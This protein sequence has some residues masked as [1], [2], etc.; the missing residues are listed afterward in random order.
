M[1]CSKT[2]DKFGDSDS[3]PIGRAFFTQFLADEH[4]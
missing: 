3:S 1:A 2:S 4:D